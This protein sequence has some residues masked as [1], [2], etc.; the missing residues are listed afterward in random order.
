MGLLYGIPF[1][2]SNNHR[3]AGL[4][5]VSGNVGIQSRRT[6]SRIDEQYS[7]ITSLHMAARH[8]DTE[9]LCFEFRSS[10]S[11][12]AGGVYKPNG[13]TIMLHKTVDCVPS[14]SCNR[15]NHCALLTDKSV[16]KRGL[17][18]IW[19][20]HNSHPD[21]ARGIFLIFFTHWHRN[22]NLV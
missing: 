14:G 12:N 22:C 6:F 7:D 11:S 13:E 17:A 3:S 21:F 15:R 8:D 4:V 5:S 20:P 9:F 1:V 18:D 19:T 2:N 10:F 16:Q